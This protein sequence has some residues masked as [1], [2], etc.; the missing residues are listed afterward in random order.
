MQEVRCVRCVVFGKVQGVWFRAGTQEVAKRLEL[1]GWVRNTSDGCVEVM[2]CGD[3]QCIE[4]LC[5]WLKQGPELA[6]VT[7]V[8]VEERPIEYFERFAIL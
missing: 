6:K 7:Q 4:Q 1:T 5:E 3:H 8:I 2:A